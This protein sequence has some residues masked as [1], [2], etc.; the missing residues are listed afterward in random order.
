MR[1][2]RA[3]STSA[4]DYFFGAASPGGQMAGRYEVVYPLGEVTPSVHDALTAE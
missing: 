2:G 1:H 4:V 3:K